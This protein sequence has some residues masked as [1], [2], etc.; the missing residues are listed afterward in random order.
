MLRTYLLAAACQNISIPPAAGAG[1]QLLT[2]AV[3]V[4]R[5]AAADAC[6]EVPLGI[7]DV[8]EAVAFLLQRLRAV[9]VLGS[10]PTKPYY[11]PPNW[12]PDFSYGAS[13]A[14]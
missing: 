3:S 4:S 2:S 6:D 1:A 8:D 13:F 14:P 12:S 10:T 9:E 5:G 7:A 11:I